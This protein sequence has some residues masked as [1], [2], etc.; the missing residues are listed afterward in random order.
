MVKK[1]VVRPVRAGAKDLGG[2]LPVWAEGYLAKHR[3]LAS[4][5]RVPCG[6]KRRSDGEPCTALSVPGRRRCKWHGGHSTGP[7][8]DQGKAKVTANLPSRKSALSAPKGRGTLPSVAGKQL[9]EAQRG[10]D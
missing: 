2:E 8:T 4:Q 7:R 3:R 6:G 5:M 1:V 9:I 10:T